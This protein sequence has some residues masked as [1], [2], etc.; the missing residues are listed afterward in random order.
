MRGR[1]G[2]TYSRAHKTNG[3]LLCSMREMMGLVKSSLAVFG[4]KTDTPKTVFFFRDS[5]CFI[6]S[7]SLLGSLVADCWATD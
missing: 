5:M 1:G 4:R 6:S 2:C 3:L 7:L